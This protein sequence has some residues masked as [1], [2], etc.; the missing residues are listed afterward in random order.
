MM[1]NIRYILENLSL[2]PP[3]CVNHKGSVQE[4]RVDPVRAG[5]GGAGPGLQKAAERRADHWGKASLG[6]SS[7]STI[8]SPAQHNQALIWRFP[9]QLIHV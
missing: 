4:T 9:A 3:S 6:G 5:V 8:P 2:F 1:A 7:P